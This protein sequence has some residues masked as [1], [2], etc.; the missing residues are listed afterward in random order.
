MS[1]DLIPLFAQLPA[2]DTREFLMKLR[3]IRLE[4]VDAL[5]RLLG[6]SPRTAEIRKQVNGHET[7]VQSDTQ[8][9]D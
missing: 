6:V 3:K 1:L 2:Q 9:K 7:V 5:E 4:E 8:R